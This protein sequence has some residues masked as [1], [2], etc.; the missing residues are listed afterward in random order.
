M[1]AL[2]SARQTL[3]RAAA[4]DPQLPRHVAV[5]MD[6]NRRWAVRNGK[7][8]QAGHR[9]GVENIRMAVRVCSDRGIAYLTCFAFSTEN[10]KRT[11]EEIDGLWSLAVEFLRSDL[12]ELVR[13][14]VR[15]RIIGDR[16]RLPGIVR[17]AAGA[18]ERATSGNRGLCLT[19]ALNY[20]AR[21]EIVAAARALCAEVAAGRLRPQDVDESIFAAHLETAD[22][23]DPDLLIRTSGEQRLS[24]FLLWQIAYSEIWVTE[25]CWPEFTEADLVAA[26]EDY[27][28]RQ[29]RF[30]GGHSEDRGSAPAAGPGTA[31]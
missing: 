5:I 22:V 7:P 18:A 28:R 2:Q 4:S 31:E 27:A 29:R 8:V 1:S 14:G 13:R 21:Q 30:G 26:L 17:Q 16:S 15:V 20:G 24:N 19:L 12:P 23:P 6:G 25:V 3:D 11:R 10:W 9:A